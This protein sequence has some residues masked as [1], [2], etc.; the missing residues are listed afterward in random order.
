MAL[1]ILGGVARRSSFPL[2]SLNSRAAMS[3]YKGGVP[4]RDEAA[5]GKERVQLEAFKAGEFD[6]FDREAHYM[7]DYSEGT[8]LSKDK[9]IEVCSSYDRRI[10]GCSCTVSENFIS[11]MWLYKGEPKRCVCGVWFQLKYKAAPHERYVPEEMLPP[12]DGKIADLE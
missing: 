6:P 3:V 11:Y 9:P 2:V 12:K 7:N 10:I 8:G 1:R 4:T 5:T